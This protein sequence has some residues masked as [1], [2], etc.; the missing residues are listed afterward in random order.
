VVTVVDKN[1]APVLKSAVP[2]ERSLTIKE[3]YQVTFSIEGTDEDGDEV[4]FTWFVDDEEVG[5]GVA[6][7]YSTDFESAGEHEISVELSDGEDVTEQSWIVTVE[8]VNRAPSLDDIGDVIVH[9]NKTLDLHLP[10]K[11]IDG[12]EITYTFDLP[13]VEDGVLV[14][15]FDDA[16]E[17]TLRI[18]A[19]DGELS[20]EETITVTVLNVDRAPTLVSIGDVDAREG[21][22]LSLDLGADDPDGD[23]LTFQLTGIDASIADGHLV[24]TPDYDTVTLPR[25]FFARMLQRLRLDWVVYS[26]ETEYPVTVSACGG[27]LCSNQSFAIVVADSN[28]APLVEEMVLHVREGE[29]LAVS[30]NASDEDGDVLFLD[31]SYPLSARGVWTP[32]FDDAGEHTVVV[33][34]NDGKNRIE[35][36]VSVIVED[37]NRN[38]AFGRLTDKKVAENE[39]IAFSVPVSDPDGDDLSLVADELPAGASFSDGVFSWTP[40]YDVVRNESSRV[41]LLTF[42]ATDDEDG[43]VTVKKSITLTVGNTNRAPVITAVSPAVPSGKALVV[44]VGQPQIFSVVAADPDGDSLQYTWKFGFLDSVSGH[45]AVQRRFTSPGVK[46]VTV[47]VS[48]G[49]DQAEHSFYIRVGQLKNQASS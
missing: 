5:E 44:L 10:E 46:E 16:G 45:A 28:R 33:G 27:E 37:V 22:E 42:S 31:Y 40:G 18:V 15:D 32:D 19:S 1:R 13:L 24:W 4:S 8:N 29:R 17:H 36:N 23:T 25:H 2:V 20:D 47:T 3:N 6:F 9:E 26:S 34:V 49:E 7:T 30:L 35:H 21:E 14:P 38:P 12:D 48:D 39:N 41:F 11:D 43:N